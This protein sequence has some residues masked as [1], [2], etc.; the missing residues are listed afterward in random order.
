[1]ICD[2]FIDSTLAYQGYGRGVDLAKI[3][4]IH[5]LATGDLIPQL[6]VL[7]DVPVE[8]GFNRKTMGKMDRFEYEGL[9][10]HNKV[11]NGYINL[12]ASEPSRWLVVDGMLDRHSISDVIFDKIVDL[13]SLP[14]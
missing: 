10:F 11:R 1:M 14:K 2:R 4:E 13:L 9:A 8:E 5:R 3:R 12:A 7:L 6:T